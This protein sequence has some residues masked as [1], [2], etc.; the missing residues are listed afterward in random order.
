MRHAPVSGPF[1]FVAIDFVE[2]KVPS[3][4][5][6]YLLSVIDHLACF[7]IIVIL[8]AIPDKSAQTVARLLVERAFSV[9][10]LPEA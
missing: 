2:Y 9:F 1:Q 8:A 3:D 4:G 7:A 10:G 5:H 6:K